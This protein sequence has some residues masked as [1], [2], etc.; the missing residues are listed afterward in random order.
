MTTSITRADLQGIK[1][2][3]PKLIR[4]F[5]GLF[6]SAATA[7]EAVNGVVGAT[8]AIQDAT[9][10]TLSPNS[11]FNNERVFTPDDQLFEVTDEGPGGRLL[12]NMRNPISTNG[13]FRC[14]FNLEAD[15]NVDLPSSGRVLTDDFSGIGQYADDAAAA[16]GGVGVGDIYR[17]T[18]GVVAWRMT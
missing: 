2:I 14:T 10:L 18:D 16:A 15:T 11:A 5:E 13:G 12:L 9:V 8:R 4:F 3:T 6:S 1:G 17:R 7:T